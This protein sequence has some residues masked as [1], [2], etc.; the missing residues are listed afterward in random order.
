MYI[1]TYIRISILTQNGAA[2]SGGGSGGGKLEVKGK[3][4]RAGRRARRDA[5]LCSGA[6][7]KNRVPA[8]AESRDEGVRC[9]RPKGVRGEPKRRGRWYTAAR[10]LGTPEAVGSDRGRGGHRAL[11]RARARGKG[12]LRRVR[13]RTAVRAA[14]HAGG[15]AGGASGRARQVVR[16]G[17]RGGWAQMA[18]GARRAGGARQAEASSG[19]GIA[20]KLLVAREEA[21]NGSCWMEN[22]RVKRSGAKTCSK[23][24]YAAESRRC[25]VG[26]CVV[27]GRGVAKASIKS[28]E[29]RSLARAQ[30]R[31][32]REGKAEWSRR[33]LGRGE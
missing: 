11:K 32:W 25:G 29:W 10:V 23:S 2:D 8:A 31:L 1:H 17:R 33:R 19:G 6:A 15:G 18:G 13:W 7:F 22:R 4:E 30:D 27:E 14:G 26:M 28:A 21:K 12:W 3:K 24:C 16:V 9:R 20:R 5:L